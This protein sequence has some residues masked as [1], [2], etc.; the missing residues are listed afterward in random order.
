MLETHA[1]RVIQHIKTYKKHYA[2][3]IFWTYAIVKAI[4][5]FAGF[6]GLMNLGQTFAANSDDG[7]IISEYI[8]GSSNNK[9]IELY[10]GTANDI[11]LFNYRI[12]VYANWG[13]TPSSVSLWGTLV[14]GDTYIIANPSAN[15]TILALADTT[16]SVIAFNWD[17]VVSLYNIT[18]DYHVDVIWQIGLDPGAYRS[19]GGVSTLDRTLVRKYHIIQWDQDGTNAFDPS[20]E[21]DMY[22][23]DTTWYLGFHDMN[24]APEWTI[25]YDPFTG[26]TGSVTASITFNESNVTITNPWW[27]YDY[28]FTDNWSFTFE[29]VDEYGLSWSATAIVTRIDQESSGTILLPGDIVF[30]TVNSDNPDAF[31]FVSRVDIVTGTKIYFTDKAWSGDDTWAISEGTIR[32]IA[33]WSITAGTPVYFESWY[34]YLYPTVRAY[35]NWPETPYQWEFNLR[36]LWD[37]IFIHQ[38][39]IYTDNTTNLIYGLWFGWDWAWLDI[40]DISLESWNSY[41]PSSLMLDTT[42]NRWKDYDNVQYNC[43]NTWMRSS[44][45]L[46]DVANSGNWVGDDGTRYPSITTTSC[47]FDATKPQVTINTWLTQQSPTSGTSV[48]F[49]A[50]F[51]EP[52]QWSTFDCSDITLIGTIGSETC[53]GITEISLNDGTTFE[54]E[55]TVAGDGT[56][57]AE[58]YS[59]K[60]LDINGNPND[61]FIAMNNTVIVDNTPP[62]ITRLGSNPV[63]T[64]YLLTYVDAWATALDT[65]DG[66]I[67]ANI[68]TWGTINTAVL[69]TYT[70]TYDVTDAA[71]NHATQ[72]TRT[73]NVVDTTPPVITRL[74]STPVSIVVGSIYIDAWVTASD[75]YDGNITSGI[76]TSGTVNVNVIGSYVITYNVTDTHSNVAIQ[77]TRT[78]N[79]VAV[80]T[81]SQWWGGGSSMQKDYCLDG[82]FSPS[83]YDNTC[84]TKTNGGNNT[85]GSAYDCTI[86]WSTYSSEANDAFLHAC[87]LGMTESTSL[88]NIDIKEY[89]LRKDVAKIISLFAVKELDMQPD[90]E[91]TCR[92]S[93]IRNES[94]D[95]QS[96]MELSCQLWIMGLKKDGTPDTIF[97]P[98]NYVTRAQFGTMLSRLIYGD[99]YNVALGSKT[100]WYYN[101]LQALQKNEIMMQISNPTIKKEMKGWIMLMLYRISQK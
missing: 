100:P 49:I 60:V 21:R 6:F 23:I 11:D 37:N 83:Y 96:Y 64:E 75:N 78:V 34:Q 58:L 9:A 8:E 66:D 45:F 51:S 81:Q 26:T 62:V 52:I 5:L 31:E 67:T 18:Y 87:N 65:N 57:I 74:G 95:L 47:T 94:E 84:G 93:D 33:S 101:H 14:A 42:A 39:T 98:N 25:I 55:I 22:A 12:S 97:K 76:V 35:M 50:E 36:H 80:V 17:D 91:R 19:G 7:L 20:L 73:V 41:I 38:S 1:P 79:V 40:P 86:E 59:G 82:D 99:M 70:G 44:G 46:N 32:F 15:W 24:T 16:S 30:I 72:V 13:T 89:I 56:V 54:I 43:V 85:H 68:V 71:G 90:I 28:I 63:N 29:F 27:S 61:D 4:L 69:G 53:S 10:N 92:F 48:K 3:W 2:F 88:K 77:V